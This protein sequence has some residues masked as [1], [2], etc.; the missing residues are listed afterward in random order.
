M[1]GLL[2]LPE[3]MFAQSQKTSE[4]KIIKKMTKTGLTLMIWTEKFRNGNS[5]HSYFKNFL[6]IVYKAVNNI[7]V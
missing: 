7:S 3:M 6:F 2:D 4:K 5:K 1:R